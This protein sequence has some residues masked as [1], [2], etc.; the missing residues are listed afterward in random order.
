MS[1][2]LLTGGH[3]IDPANRL[4]APADVL[5]RDG[6]ISAVGPDGRDD[7]HGGGSS[8]C[9][10]QNRRGSGRQFG[11]RYGIRSGCVGSGYRR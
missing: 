3:V 9:G 6:K 4:D 11:R 2:L 1:S 10:K 7:E 5:I 8:G